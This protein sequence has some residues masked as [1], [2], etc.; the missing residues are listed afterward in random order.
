MKATTKQHIDRYGLMYVFGIAVCSTLFPF[1][2]RLQVGAPI[3]PVATSYSFFN[4]VTPMTPLLKTG[5]SWIIPPLLA[6]VFLSLCTLYLRKFYRRSIVVFTLLAIIVSPT[7]SVLSS[8]LNDVMLAM[9]FLVAGLLYRRFQLVFL[10]LTLVTNPVLG[11]LCMSYFLV[12]H[13][14]KPL[15]LL[16][17][18]ISCAVA[19]LWYTIWSSLPTLTLSFAPTLYELGAEGVSI[20]FII[21]GVHGLLSRH[22]RNKRA[23]LLL[24]LGAL[25]L[26]LFLPDLTFVAVLLLSVLVGHS[27]FTLLTSKWELQLLQQ[28]VIVIGFCL[29]LFLIVS[30]SK[31]LMVEQPTKGM[32]DA[33]MS[34]K[35]QLQ[36][37][38]ILTITAY[39]PIVNHFSGRTAIVNEQLF[40]S[41]NPSEVYAFLER[42]NTRYILLTNEMK[43]TMFEHSDEGILFVLPNTQR[44]VRAYNTD[45]YEFWYYIPR[46]T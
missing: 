16:G 9:I 36:E 15:H 21:F 22:L 27:M 44:F 6:L 46:N 43:D 25:S 40:H 4:V 18:T 11:L 8:T 34:L 3:I 5:F 42:T 1:L 28:T 23:M 29:G 32:H 39:A 37:G 35:D 19:A 45:G 24:V 30:A 14:K 17:L 12:L 2:L 20:F 26:A 41:R 33:M 7:F 10:T 38:N 31:E 13:R